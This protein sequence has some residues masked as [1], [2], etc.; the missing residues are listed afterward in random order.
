M[1]I[2]TNDA[3]YSLKPHI[4]LHKRSNSFDMKRQ[5]LL[6]CRQHPFVMLVPSGAN[7]SECKVAA[8]HVKRAW[9]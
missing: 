5:K 6:F 9:F 4:T 7:K 2:S 1:M 8:R 3:R